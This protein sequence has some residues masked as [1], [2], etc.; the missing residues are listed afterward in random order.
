[1][2]R[3]RLR[4]P[5]R[6]RDTPQL[7]FVVQTP[8]SAWRCQ[9]HTAC[10]SRARAGPPRC[11][12]SAGL[13]LFVRPSWTSSTTITP[14]SRNGANRADRA[15]MTMRASPRWARYIH[16]TARPGPGAVHERQLLAEAGLEA[17][18][19][20][21]RERDL[22]HATMPSAPAAGHVHAMQIDLVLPLPVTPWMSSSRFSRACRPPG[23]LIHGPLASLSF[24]KS[25]PASF[26]S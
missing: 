11:H 9:Q 24:R 2:R 22:G 20:L 25:I 23:L 8:P 21:R 15:P 18:D 26:Q 12:D 10:S 1:L 7:G 4:A 14:T 13:L 19:H 16:Q 3:F 17:P 5:S 6:V